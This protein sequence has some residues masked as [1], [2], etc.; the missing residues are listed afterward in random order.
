[1]FLKKLFDDIS[2]K[3]FRK[4]FKIL[5]L[6]KKEF[7]IATTLLFLVT[8][9]KLPMP[10][11]TGYIIDKV[12]VKDNVFMLNF[13]CGGLILVTLVYILVGYFKDFVLFKT[14]QQII[15][16]L[17]S[18]LLNHI[19]NVKTG[20]I[21]EYESGYLVSRILHDPQSLNGMFLQT[22]MMLF[23]SSF[24]ILVG[25]AMIL[26]INWKLAVCSL[27]I[28]PFYI[29]ANF[30]NLEKIRYWD[31]MTKEQGAQINRGLT[32][33]IMGIK[34]IKL[35]NMKQSEDM[36]FNGKLE[37]ELN[38]RCKGFFYGYIV[39][40]AGNFFSA[41]G[42]LLVVWYG[43]YQVI[44][45]TLTIGQ[46]VAFS[47][48][49][50][51]L[52][53]PARSLLNIHLGFQKS[54]VSLNRI[55][56]IL[57]IETENDIETE[58]TDREENFSVEFCDVHFSYGQNKVLDGLNFSVK[59]GEKI[60]LLGNSGAGK[61]TIINLLAGFIKPESG[62]IRTGNTDIS[63]EY[64]QWMRR[65]SG[66]ITQETFLF[67]TSIYENILI[68]RPGASEEEVIEAARAA[69]AYHFISSLPEG[70]NTIVGERGTRL[71]GGQR[72]LICLARVILKNPGIMILDEPTSA[73][74]SESETLLFDSLRNF[75]KDRTVIVVSH[76]LS[77][78]SEVDRMII[79]DGG[80]IV[81][82]G[83]HMELLEENGFYRQIHKAQIEIKRGGR[84]EDDKG[85]EN[86]DYSKAAV[87]K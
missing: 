28:L 26:V 79:L 30:L 15:V 1:M 69:N 9:M 22:Y 40:G 13:L 48:L 47:S 43:G 39:T 32:E 45:G 11:L 36:K 82:S 81:A 5:Q 17:R 75:I 51:F 18:K 76:R 12:I 20:R 84:A 74:D 58:E 7:I 53:S 16:K 34:T 56:E 78:V 70:M 31:K 59:S 55:Y 83:K 65:N 68:G 71:S 4:F 64:S 21:S 67:S 37:K 44:T 38:Y 8:L 23:Q 72:Q 2:R 46:L 61:T 33:S 10:L 63:E 87:N 35:F 6:F 54:L 24:T 80:R 50:G 52:Y 66:F 3:N 42:P 14:Q 29:G 85:Y 25:I 73:V 86:T 60:A 62:S 27:L 19:F 41:M 49:L 57:N 77:F